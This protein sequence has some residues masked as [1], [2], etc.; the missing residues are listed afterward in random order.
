MDAL[1]QL[2]YVG[3]VRMVSLGLPS[4]A[5]PKQK[6]AAGERRYLLRASR[7]NGSGRQSEHD[8]EY[9]EWSSS[10]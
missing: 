6:Q 10:A 9:D 1:Y 7:Q 8:R 2:S 5:G 3:T 4:G